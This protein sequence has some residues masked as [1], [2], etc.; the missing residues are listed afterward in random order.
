MKAYG[1]PAAADDETN[2]SVSLSS[3]SLS[4]TPEAME[5]FAKFIAF[6]ASEMKRLGTNYDHVH[7]MDFCKTTWDGTWPDIQITK[8][9][10]L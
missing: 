2:H 4:V 8:V 6:A 10:G 9:Y 7:F 1:V 5:Q 3:V